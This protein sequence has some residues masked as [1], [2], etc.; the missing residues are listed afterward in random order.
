[1]S[2][3]DMHKIR[4]NSHSRANAFGVKWEVGERRVEDVVVTADFANTRVLA[5]ESLPFFLGY[6]KL[7]A[8]PKVR[9]VGGTCHTYC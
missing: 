3:F 2:L 9:A 1:M 6:D 5:T 4:R 7:F 8:I